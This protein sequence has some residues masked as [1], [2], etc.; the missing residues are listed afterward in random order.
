MDNHTEIARIKAKIARL[1]A[2]RLELIKATTF[3]EETLRLIN[4]TVHAM[5]AKIRELQELDLCVG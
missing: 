1:E 5:Y 4:T 3:K 2:K